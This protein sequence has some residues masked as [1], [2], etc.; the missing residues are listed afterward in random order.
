VHGESQVAVCGR[1]A[2]TDHVPWSKPHSMA[3]VTLVGARRLAT[4][5]ARVGAPGAGYSSWNKASGKPPKS[6]MVFGRS[7]PVTRVL[8]MYQ[9]AE[10]ASTAVGRGIL[11][12]MAAQ[13]V[14]HGL[15]CNA[16][17]GLP[18]PMKSAGMASFAT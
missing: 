13:A 14:V 9:W 17:I 16:F 18:C 8:R 12:P 15:T 6:W 1:C 4:R 10:I 5:A 3:T 11:R 2:S 7:L